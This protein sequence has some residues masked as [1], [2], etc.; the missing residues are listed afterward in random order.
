MGSKASATDVFPCS[1]DQFFQ[2]VTDYEK[3]HEFLAE[4]KRCKV[5][6]TESAAGVATKLVE[7]RV[8]LM[9]EFKYELLMKEDSQKKQVQ[10]SFAGGD[11][12]KNLLGSWV[13]VDEGGKCRATYSIEAEF[14]LLVPG[15]IAKALVSV[16]LPNMMSSYQKRVK[17]IIG[18][19][20]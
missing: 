18:S 1:C 8:S 19:A 12:F 3:Y 13:L 5:L 20:R 6:K 15:P 17:E 16:N 11:L 4:V 2:I 14:G 9:K 7:Y 10:W